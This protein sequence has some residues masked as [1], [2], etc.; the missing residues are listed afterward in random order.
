MCLKDIK[1]L[2]NNIVIDQIKTIIS[3]HTFFATN[4]YK[5]HLML[6]NY[7]GWLCNYSVFILT[8][9]LQSSSST[10]YLLG[11]IVLFVDFFYE[12]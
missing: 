2:R 1:F 8:K 11:I 9:F 10:K 6:N 7:V 5:L 4:V 12:C 3:Y